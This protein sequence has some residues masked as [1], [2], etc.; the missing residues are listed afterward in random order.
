MHNHRYYKANISIRQM[1][2]AIDLWQPL[3]LKYFVKYLEKTFQ[4]DG[5][6]AFDGIVVANII[7]E[8]RETVQSS[9][10]IATG[11]IPCWPP[12]SE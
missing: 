8:L 9:I 10:A 1:L 6:M 3:L 2:I 11:A 12:N 5:C 7:K 4:E